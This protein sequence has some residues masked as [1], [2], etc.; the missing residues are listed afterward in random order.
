MGQPGRRVRGGHQSVV[1]GFAL[2]VARYL[3]RLCPEQWSKLTNSNILTLNASGRAAHRKA[4]AEQARFLE[5]I[6]K[7]QSETKVSA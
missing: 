5:R 2:W 1:G 7:L 6:E 4:C 3:G